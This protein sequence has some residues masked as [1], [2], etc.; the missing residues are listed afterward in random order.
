MYKR[1]LDLVEIGLKRQISSTG[2]G[3]FRIFFGLLTLHEVGFLFYFRHLIFDPVPFLDQ[4]SPLIAFFLVLWGIAAFFLAVGRYTRCAALATY[5]FWIIFLVFTPM[6]QEFDGGF[7]QLMVAGSLL[8]IVV[9]SERALSL[10]NLRLKL[11]YSGADSDYRPEMKVSVLSYHIPIVICLGLV[12]F[13]SALHKMSAEFWRNGLGAWLPSTMPYYIS[14]IDMSWLLNMKPVQIAIGYTL[15]V[16]QFVFI[17]LFFLRKFRVPLLLIGIAFHGGITLSLNIYPFGLGMLAF[18]FLMVPVCWWR[19]IRY[20]LRVKNPLLTVFYDEKCPLCIRAV[21]VVEHFDAIAAID[22]K[23]RQAQ[24][25]RFSKIE[26]VSDK[27][28]SYDLYAV[29]RSGKLYC[30]LDTYIQILLKMKYTAFIGLMALIPGIYPVCSWVYRQISARG[31]RVSHRRSC[32]GPSSQAV[33]RNQPLEAFSFLPFQSAQGLSRRITKLLIIVFFLQLNSTIHYGI[34]YRLDVD[35]RATAL[36]RL[37]TGI[38]DRVILFT[39]A[40]LG[41][42]PHGLYVDDHLKGFDHLFAFTYNNY[43]DEETWLPFINQEGRIVAP[44]WGRI[45]SMWANVAIMADVDQKR[46]FKFTEKVTAFWCAK[47]GL[48]L[49]DLELTIKMKEIQTPAEWERDLRNKNIARPWRNIG[50]VIWKNGSMTLD[51]PEVDLNAL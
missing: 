37:V 35:R 2:L 17:F 46:F 28:A 14:A 38:S 44:N 5:V 30:G 51:I 47:I 10:D 31:H 22:F 20:A 41:I 23:G 39:H 9:P 12:Y 27:K 34:L 48:D 16:F 25:T 3:V 36:T 43:K 42:T 6:W 8:L 13:D 15:L 19:Q 24:A 4:S 45:Q 11:N 26:N 1:L 21:I 32:A 18:Y 49:S 50:R 7:D 33:P 29:D 40:F